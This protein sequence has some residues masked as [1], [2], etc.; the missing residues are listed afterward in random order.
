MTINVTYQ[1]KYKFIY[2]DL[3]NNKNEIKNLTIHIDLIQPNGF[4]KHALIKNIY[5]L[6]YDRIKFYDDQIYYV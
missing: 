2:V 6:L 5:F 4:N 3:K 1:D